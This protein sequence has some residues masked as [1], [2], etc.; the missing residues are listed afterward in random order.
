MRASSPRHG[1]RRPSISRRYNEAGGQIGKLENWG[2]PQ[3]HSSTL[4]RA[5]GFNAWRDFI[6][7]LLDRG[8]MIDSKTGEPFTDAALELALRDVFETIRTDGWSSIKPGSAGGQD[9]RQSEGRASVP[10][11]HRRRRWLAYHNK[12]GSGSPFDAMMGHIEA[13]SRDTALMEILG[14]NPAATMRWLKDTIEKSAQ[15]D[16]R[17]ARRRSRSP[18]SISLGSNAL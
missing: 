6:A 5:A 15:L 7:P 9:A 3:S 14:P 10:A 13:M 2:L 12:F 11:L 18:T 16:A 17:R 1:A 8:R 4:V